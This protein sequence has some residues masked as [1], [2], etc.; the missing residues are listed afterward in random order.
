MPKYIVKNEQILKEFMGKFWKYL[1]SKKGRGI[2]KVFEKDPVMKGLM[3][4]AQNIN[5]KIQ[6]R[7]KDKEAEFWK[8]YKK[9]HGHNIFDD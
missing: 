7:I 4:Q 2:V 1:G 5:N 8:D 9:K 6:K 3:N